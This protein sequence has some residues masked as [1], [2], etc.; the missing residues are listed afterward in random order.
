MAGKYGKNIAGN[1]VPSLDPALL[2]SYR[3]VWSVG[4][5]YIIKSGCIITKVSLSISQVVFEFF[6]FKY[7]ARI[8]LF[9]QKLILLVKLFTNVV[10]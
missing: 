9:T 8:L 7:C 3:T 1:S 4:F 5:R 10:N 6:G 2:D